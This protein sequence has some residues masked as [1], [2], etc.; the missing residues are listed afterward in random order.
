[1][2]RSRLGELGRGLFLWHDLLV[3]LKPR[4][5]LRRG[6]GRRRMLVTIEGCIR[7]FSLVLQARRA[8]SQNVF[9]QVNARL[10]P[11]VHEAGVGR[12]VALG[13]FITS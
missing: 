7:V 12:E 11:L 3:G 8:T 6:R 13:L 9:S 10:S 2:L 4:A 5:G 1:M